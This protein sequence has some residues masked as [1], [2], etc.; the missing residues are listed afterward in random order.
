MY[1]VWKRS[2]ALATAK[3]NPN[4]AAATLH[5]LPDLYAR[6]AELTRWRSFARVQGRQLAQ[7]DGSALVR[8][9]AKARDQHHLDQVLKNG[10]LRVAPAY[11]VPVPGTGERS[12][13]FTATVER[14]KL[15]QLQPELQLAWEL[16]VPMRD[17]RAVA[18]GTPHGYFGRT[19]DLKAFNPGSV[20]EPLPPR[21]GKSKSGAR[22]GDTMAVIDFGCPFLSTVF[23]DRAASSP[24]TRIKALWDQGSNPPNGTPN[25]KPWAQQ[26]SFGYGRVLDAQS[27]AWLYRNFHKGK[28]L[29]SN[30]EHRAY[31][32]LDYLIAYDDPR[33]R[34]W[35][36]T[37][38]SHVLDMAAGSID[39]L[40]HAKG[41]AASK[42]DLLFVQLPAL[43]AA[44]SS[45][46]SL[47]AQLLDAVRFALEQCDPS[48]RLV[49][50]ISYGTFAGPHD[51]SS[52]IEQALDEL[53]SLRSNNFA[54]VIGAGNAKG[55]R[56][57]ARRHVTAERPARLTFKLSEG[58]TCDSFVEV[59]YERPALGT[60]L[61]LRIRSAE[62]DWSDWVHPGTKQCLQDEVRGDVVC[63]VL[64]EP[65]VSLGRQALVLLAFAPTAQ[66]DDDD[67]CLLKPGT[68]E[69]EL[70]VAGDTVAAEGISVHA[71]VER[72]D[73]KFLRNAEQPHFLD[74]E[75]DDDTNCL[76]N[77]A[78]GMHT[79]VVG[80]FRLSSGVA[81]RYSSV[82]PQRLR[83]NH[84]LPLVYAACEEDELQPD[85]LAAAVRSH[86]RFR[87]SGTSV[88]APVLARR[89]FNAMS[90]KRISRNDWSAVLGELCQTD[91]Y[92]RPAD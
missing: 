60:E 81:A 63:A 19:V 67:G 70:A 56:C 62:G 15:C 66:P 40:G 36:S 77:L 30:D 61:K 43:T 42:A 86:E 29:R 45:G 64:H 12:L 32:G 18:E 71:W 91:E 53:L 83:S 5:M 31:R 2:N 59:W 55:A 44:D 14:G 75:L 65:N 48:S 68:W 38:G 49:V 39:P 9:L 35:F 20:F 73:P 1:Q 22:L 57:H 88:A 54:I 47:G 58:L 80:G 84:P 4:V 74:V 23:A 79:I 69:I 28:R 92:L 72:D 26:Q 25:K 33:R 34:I 6:W 78:T 16:A 82:G 27:L 41:D 10:L 8:I 11:H 89:I 17:A 76:S 3:Q 52:L 13:F 21:A 46:A 7:S 24:R 85:L 50:N 90:G 51:G 37:H 87:M